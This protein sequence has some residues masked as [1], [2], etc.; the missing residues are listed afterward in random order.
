MHAVGSPRET[1]TQALVALALALCAAEA[2]AGAWERA[3][4]TG[5]VALGQEAG[6]SAESAIFAE[7]GLS[8]GWT[9]GADGAISLADGSDS[10]ALGFIRRSFGSGSGRVALELGAGLGIEDGDSAPLVRP[11]V[12][13]GQGFGGRISGWVALDLSADVTHL[14]NS[15]KAVATLGLRPAPAWMTVSQ[16]QNE[17][18]VGGGASGLAATQSVIYELRPEMRLELGVT[19]GVSGGIDDR[20]RLGT[21][22]GF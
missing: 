6:G 17:E 7:W 9:V 4:G 1:C 20:I 2:S 14:G 19:V 21:W 16:I 3:E 15:A 13:V 22:F 8:G 5:F 12:S 11:V 18:F 10:R